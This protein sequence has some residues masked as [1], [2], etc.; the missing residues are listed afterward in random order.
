MRHLVFGLVCFAFGAAE[1]WFR[2]VIF[3]NRV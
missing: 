3:A 1:F 2:G